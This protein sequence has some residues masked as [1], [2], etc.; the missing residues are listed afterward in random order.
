MAD[1][2]SFSTF[3]WIK[4]QR[5]LID[6]FNFLNCVLVGDTVRVLLEQQSCPISIFMEDCYGTCISSLH[7]DFLLDMDMDSFMEF[8]I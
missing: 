2:A 1:P 8:I 4:S 6:I 7:V 5:F 3:S